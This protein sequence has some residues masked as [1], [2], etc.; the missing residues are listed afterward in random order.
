MTKQ[1]GFT[2]IELMIV[3]IVVAILAS[4]AIP[5]YRTMIVKN[6]EAQAQAKMQQLQNELEAWRA[7]SLTYR[8]FMP[9]KVADNGA[10]TYAYSSGN[11][12]INIP[13]N[14]PSY[15]ITLTNGSGKT[16]V[17]TGSDFAG[18]S[19]TWVMIARPV[20]SR[21]SANEASTF[22]LNSEG[23]KCQSRTATKQIKTS[24][25]NCTAVG[26]STW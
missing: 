9:K 7:T 15:Q 1:K 14:N 5:S 16:L 4:I 6:A 22:M 24:M 26:V 17:P 21:W 19:N 8:G 23:L 3:V 18:A 12:I 20:A 11:T 25:K 13:E 2:L 10:V